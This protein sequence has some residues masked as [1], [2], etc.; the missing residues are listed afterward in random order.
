MRT[1]LIAKKM[2]MSRVFTEDGAHIPV[3]V[4]KVDDNQVVAQRTNDKDG[5]TAIQVGTTDAKV[6]HLTKAQRGHFAKAGVAPRRKLVEFRV[7]D[8]ALLPVGAELSVNHFVVGQKVDVTGT[9][10]GA[11]FTGVMVRHNFG[12]MR[13]SHG[14]SVSHRA[15]GSTGNNQDPGRVFKGK[16]MAGHMGDKQITTQS[17]EVAAIDAENGLILVRGSVPG[18]K[19]GYVLINDAVKLKLHE[20]VPYP[21]GLVEAAAAEAPAAE[22]SVEA[23]AAEEGN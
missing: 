13:A 16:K 17:L 2:G 3:T 11:G 22:A 5:Y 1:G 19:Q 23:P 9:S 8:D 15:H 12:G 10:K 21:A 18:A 6:K 20:G 14:V 7:S 4:L